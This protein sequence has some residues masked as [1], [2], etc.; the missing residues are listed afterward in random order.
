MMVLSVRELKISVIMHLH[1]WII[2]Y[3]NFDFQKIRLSLGK[4]NIEFLGFYTLRRC[5][6]VGSFDQGNFPTCLLVMQKTNPM[7]TYLQPQGLSDRQWSRH[8][9]MIKG[10]IAETLIQELFLSL[11]YCVFPFGME[12]TIPGI[13]EHIKGVHN[14]VSEDIRRMPDF[15]V[16]PPKSNELYFIEVKFRASGEFSKKDLPQNYSYTNAHIILVSKKHIKCLT[17]K[18]ILA[19]QEFTPT[20]KNYLGSRKEFE[21]D[22]EVIIDFCEFATQFFNGV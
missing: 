6:T 16:R 11:N 3:D 22:R 14:E 18:E 17:V 8:H 5:L 9:N 10:R 19:G 1:L 13:M 4:I 7:S 2:K 12:N 20:S 21:L 15:V